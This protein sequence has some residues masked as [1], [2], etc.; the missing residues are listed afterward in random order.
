MYAVCMVGSRG[1]IH[2][3]ILNITQ[4]LTADL[5]YQQLQHVYE[6]L[7]KYSVLVNRNNDV[8]LNDNPRPRS[9]RIMQEKALDFV[10]LFNSSTIFSRSCTE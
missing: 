1:I 2:F 5:F 8:I 6:S 4:I 10:G 3:E 7:R 9:A